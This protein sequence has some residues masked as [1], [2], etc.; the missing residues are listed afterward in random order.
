LSSID[1]HEIWG[2]VDVVEM[3]YS[4]RLLGGFAI[5]SGDGRELSLPTRKTCALLAY[6]A[7]NVDRPQRRE[8]LIALLWGDRD[9]RQARRSLNQALVSIRKL[10][11]DSNASFLDSDADFVT[12]R[13]RSLESDVARFREL[14]DHDPAGAAGLY[15]GPFLDG[16]SIPEREFNDWLSAIRS[17]MHAGVCGALSRVAEAA[18]AKGDSAQAIEAAKRLVALDP[19]REDGHRL[20]MRLLYEGG[21]RIGALRQYLACAEI[22][23]AE[24]QVEPDTAT[25]ALY[26]EIKRDAAGPVELLSRERAPRAQHREIGTFWSVGRRWF[27]AAVA[28]CVAIIILAGAVVRI[29]PWVR[30]DKTVAQY[31]VSLSDKPSIAVMP[32]K[33][34]SD[35]PKQDYLSDGIAADIVTRLARR[36]DMLV[37]AHTLSPFYRGKLPKE[38]Q[39]GHALEAEYVLEGSIQKAGDRIRIT[40]QLIEIAT[41]KHLMAERYDRSADNLFDMQDEIT[42]SVAAEL[43]A[44]L[45]AGEVARINFQ[46]TDNFMAYDYF[47]RGVEA[48][49]KRSKANHERAR[50]LFEKAIE[51]DPNFARAIAYLGW[52]YE[53][54]R[55]QRGWGY[56][57]EESLKRAEDLALRALAIDA[58][59]STAHALLGYLNSYKGRH[60]RAINEGRRAV[61]I[62][63][64]NP[65]HR[66]TLGWTMLFAGR[67]QE[68]SRQVARAFCLSPYPTD[69]M[70]S[71]AAQTHYMSGRYEAAIGAGKKLLERNTNRD[72]ISRRRM[73]ASYMAM[74]RL[75]EARAE[76][77]KHNEAYMERHG[78]PYSLG[79]RLETLRSRPWK[80]TTWIDVYADRLRRAGIP[81]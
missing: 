58:I 53:A 51:L 45:T 26:D 66:I 64:S 70:L 50:Q 43:A 71:I 65:S 34:L 78:K 19:L 39:I 52:V 33:N 1:Q 49:D 18:S 80:D 10:A 3:N 56:D 38:L 55:Y 11:D 8:S 21:D 25:Q 63:P 27:V 37:V 28:G 36:P 74:G 41:G 42:Y 2:H 54:R 14:L 62:E 24:L 12:L 79:K 4:L 77:K 61:A 72:G 15:D 22:L 16:V 13:S 76:A 68:A 47:L 31:C 17:E 75:A 6:L 67:P 7:V 40:A 48:Y 5:R 69:G 23:N 44:K 9:E 46:S 35:D 57:P 32:F 29:A 81:E 60:D 73:I 59:S 30:P 20:L